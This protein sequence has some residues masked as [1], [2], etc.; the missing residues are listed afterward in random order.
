MIFSHSKLLG[1]ESRRCGFC[2]VEA[3]TEDSE[4]RIKSRNCLHETDLARRKSKTEDHLSW[5]YPP[6][7]MEIDEAAPVRRRCQYVGEAEY[8]EHAL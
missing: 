7:F 8:L 5:M 6:A 4:S 2:D 1:S 3:E